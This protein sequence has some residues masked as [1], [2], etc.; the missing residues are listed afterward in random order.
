MLRWPP[1]NRAVKVALFFIL[2]LELTDLFKT[3]SFL[4]RIFLN[5]DIDIFFAASDGGGLVINHVLKHEDTTTSSLMQNFPHCF[6]STMRNYTNSVTEE[7]V[8]VAQF[9]KVLNVATFTLRDDNSRRHDSY[10]HM[11][12]IMKPR[13]FLCIASWINQ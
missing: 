12:F 7:V 2:A 5:H 10:N 3:P 11:C 8:S 4:S 1:V 6:P 9:L 13:Y